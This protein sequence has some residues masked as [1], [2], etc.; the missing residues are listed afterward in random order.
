MATQ[1]FAPDA[2]NS[3]AASRTDDPARPGVLIQSFDTG[4]QTEVGR[5]ASLLG[6]LLQVGQHIDLA[7]ID[8]SACRM[9]EIAESRQ[10]PACIGAHARPH[11][12]QRRAR[13]PLPAY[14]RRSLEDDRSE[15]VLF[16][17]AG[18][19]KAGRAAA[20]NGDGLFGHVDRIE[21][22]IHGASP[23]HGRPEL[24]ASPDRG[25]PK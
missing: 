17:E 8:T 4:R 13:I 12:A 15:A 6:I 21:R 14:R 9:I 10:Y 20:D 1:T 25:F 2:A 16:E 7:R 23:L 18:R 19:D 22:S 3:L 24:Y 11:S 5:K